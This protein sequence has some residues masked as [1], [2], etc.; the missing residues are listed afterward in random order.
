MRVLRC[1]SLNCK[2]FN[3]THFYRL[4]LA[5]KHSTAMCLPALPVSVYQ[6]N[7]LA[8]FPC[9]SYLLV[10]SLVFLSLFKDDTRM[11]ICRNMLAHDRFM[12]D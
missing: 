11:K 3:C 7:A 9:I 10:V 2:M 5:F 1:V 4:P 12:R 8:F 6:T